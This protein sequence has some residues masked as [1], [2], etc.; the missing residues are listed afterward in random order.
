MKQ[1]DAFFPFTVNTWQHLVRYL[2]AMYLRY[3]VLQMVD[4]NFLLLYHNTYKSPKASP[5]VGCDVQ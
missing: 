2:A 3:P 5:V 4:T 1:S